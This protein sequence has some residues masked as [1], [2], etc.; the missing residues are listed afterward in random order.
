MEAD[1]VQFALED[2]HHRLPSVLRKDGSLQAATTEGE[3]S[4]VSLM[5]M[6]IFTYVVFSLLYCHNYVYFFYVD[7]VRMG[8]PGINFNHH[9]FSPSFANSCCIFCTALPP[10]IVSEFPHLY[11]VTW[12]LFAFEYEFYYL[13]NYNII[14]L[15]TYLFCRKSSLFQSY[16]AS[17]VRAS[18]TS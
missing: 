6:G 8:C 9:N 17:F 5:A 10:E 1:F 11:V 12:F 14:V 15:L 7:S 3:S 2:I 16:M 18:S 4:E 13:H